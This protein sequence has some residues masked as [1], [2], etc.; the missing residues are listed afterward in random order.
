[1]RCLSENNPLKGLLFVILLFVWADTGAQRYPF[2]NLSI[3]QGLIQSQA[4]CMAQDKAGHLWIGTLG[5]LSRYDGH[6]FTSYSVR[7]GLPDNGIN[8]LHIDAVGQI[9]IGT[10]KGLAVY[11]GRSFKQYIFQSSEN[12]Q[13]NII[14]SIRTAADGT[15]W[16]IAG[17]QIYSIHKG[18]VRS[19]PLPA[20]Y[21]SV[22]AIYVGNND[23]LYAAMP[24]ANA[25]YTYRGGEWDS[26]RL[27]ATPAPYFINHFYENKQKQLWLL[28]NNGI[29][30]LSGKEAATYKIPVTP[31]CITQAIDGAYWIGTNNGIVRLTDSTSRYY[32]KQNGF[33]DNAIFDVLTDKEGNIWMASDGQGLFRFS[34]APFIAYDESIKLP[35][36]QV[37]ALVN[38]KDDLYFGT[39]DAGLYCYSENGIR[40]IKLPG[41]VKPPVIALA[42]R[43]NDL[44]IGTRGKGLYRYNNGK[45]RE[46]NTQNSQVSNF[47]YTLHTSEDGRLWVGMN[48]GVAIFDGDSFY[49]LPFRDAVIYGFAETGTDSMLI[50]TS[51][52]I[53]LY[54]NDEVRPFMTRSAI[55]SV[56]PQCLTFLDNWL[57]VGTS[58]NGVVGYNRLT[59]RSIVINKNNGLRSDFVYN[60]FA[61][62]DSSV[63]AGTG[64]GI[65]NIR[66]K[67]D[68]AVVTFY[69]RGQGVTG[70]E[71]NHNAV[72]GMPDGSIW[73]GTT[74][75]A[76]HYRP[77]AQ[78][79][80]PRP[81]SIVLQSVK[82]FGESITDTN[83]YTS[84]TPFYNVPVGLRLPPRKNNLTFNFQAVS[85]SDES[86]LTYRY[87]MEGLDAQWSDWASTNTITYSALPSGKYALHVQCS[88]N[89][90][91]VKY[92]LVYPFE[93]I[94]PFHKTNLFRVLI[95]GGCIL[96]GVSIQYIANKRKQSRQK[97]IE[98][99]RREEQAK[100][101][102]RTAE[103]FHDEVGNKLTRINVLTNVLKTKLTNM[104]PDAER[105]ITQIQ[106]NTGQLYSGTRDILWSLKPSNDTVYEILHRIRDFGQDL[107]GD[108]EVLF[109]FTGTEEHWKDYRLPMDISRNLIM[110]FKEAM[111]NSLKY[112]DATS[113]TLDAV[114]D[115]SG[116]LTLKL[117]DNGRGFDEQ[118]IKRG[119]GLHN[120]AI[121]AKRIDG[122][123][124]ITP[125]EG[126]GTRLLL[127][128]KIPQSKG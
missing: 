58:D 72:L 123:L 8:A 23:L 6:S 37:M 9:W 95:F 110:I 94:T 43:D 120:M 79:M 20:T 31:T 107:F 25:V 66:L 121:R 51:S 75:G 26:I 124:E 96:L 65:Y 73:F 16:C 10:Q 45:L 100:V 22:T 5:G 114:L 13:G 84:V 88:A 56:S 53:K 103:D 54:D 59:G 67:K 68:Q 48:N 42:S 44:W 116:T 19:I 29:T 71:S 3:E 105:I 104:P 2:Y 82:L 12:P 102:E 64:F 92:E 41:N 63:W 97:M 76:M 81:V 38:Y 127:I 117:T 89:G 80:T 126:K 62:R 70:V 49:R 101:R 113:V 39:Y 125:G 91:P 4:T 52:G 93:I 33:T 77:G 27:P 46:Y 11:D 122:V 112:A 86:G 111:N 109:T 106:D 98:A 50:A 87:R 15:A 108:T 28:S 1:M 21:K 7:D 55:D 47:I 90:E 24:G 30:K 34:G 85:L 14:F 61:A 36:A 119:N 78:S 32:N 57:W 18:Q 35:S 99:L 74:N 17:K 115:N 83:Y 69:G 118:K 128:F 60:I 40:E